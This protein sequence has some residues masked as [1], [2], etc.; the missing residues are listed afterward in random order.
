M[1]TEQRLLHQV[2]RDGARYVSEMNDRDM[3][4]AIVMDEVTQPRLALRG[5][6]LLQDCSFPARLA[7]VGCEAEPFWAVEHVVHVKKE[8]N[9]MGSS[10]INKVRTQEQLKFL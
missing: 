2:L 4:P 9:N 5:P 3:V 1:C 6:L 10:H 7:V 8:L